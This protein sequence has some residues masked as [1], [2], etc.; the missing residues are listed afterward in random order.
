M[1]ID[2]NDKESLIEEINL[3]GPWTHGYFDLGNGLVIEDNDDIQKTRLFKY[4]D[5][6]EDIIAR[7]YGRDELPEKTLCEIGCNSGYFIFE[8]LKR[9]KFGKVTGLE[10]R[11][12]NL[13]KARFIKQM[14]NLSDRVFDLCD[15]DILA[16]EAAGEPF[17]VVL[18]PGVLHHLDNHLNALANL[19]AMTGDL[20]I[21]ETI[22][23]PE[24]VNSD[25]SRKYLEL[26]DEFYLH[27][28]DY[29]GLVGYKYE[30]ADLDGSAVRD[31]IVG[32]PT[33]KALM[34]MLRHVGF[35]DIEVY[36]SVAELEAEI[37][38]PNLYR[39]VAVLIVKCTKR[40]T[41]QSEDR[42]AAKLALEEREIFTCLP[43]E[44]AEQL[45]AYCEGRRPLDALDDA[46]RL[47]VTSQCEYSTADGRTAW[48]RLSNDFDLT[49]DELAILATL[50]HAFHQKVAFEYAKTCYRQ[51]KA[52][53]CARVLHDL[54]RICNLDW[55]TVYRS[56]FLL[57]VI[58]LDK[59]EKEA[60]RGFLE[61]VL[62]A[63][64]NF[65]LAR[66]LSEIIGDP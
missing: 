20:C 62:R 53:E 5:Y 24:S 14:F 23:L 4:R 25:R 27:N 31:G 38:R 47:V 22:V 26:K 34:M 12:S 39:D 56:Y 43:A 3:L 15:Y 13:A 58:H 29:F 57:A 19:Y 30:S 49:K 16:N 65:S 60:G 52:D 36:K 64:P 42:H 46:A 7:H 17:D 8:M 48:Q 45:Y 6:F 10:P 41:N 11:E 51:E 40:R 44:M 1:T 66:R 50:K 9:F 2:I 35:E 55:R 18:M 33:E 63:H 59:K 61:K 21:I 28:Q 54:I 32:V 37:Y